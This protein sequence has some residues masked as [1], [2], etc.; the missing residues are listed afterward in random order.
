MALGGVKTATVRD[1]W[2][3]AVEARA[4]ELLRDGVKGCVHVAVVLG[5][6]EQKLASIGIGPL[7]RHV[8]RHRHV[9]HKQRSEK[10]L[11]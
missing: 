11:Q 7:S 6:G 2:N 4:Q 10:A 3:R 5:A 9:L 8:L 1:L